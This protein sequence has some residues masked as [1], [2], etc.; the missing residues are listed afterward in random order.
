MATSEPCGTESEE[1]TAEPIATVAANPEEYMKHPL[2]NKWA[3]WYFK[4]DKSKSW[5]ENL[6]LIA[7]FDT[8]EDFWA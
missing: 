7:K 2:Q 6:R 3:L 4:N 5:T 1:S 8:V